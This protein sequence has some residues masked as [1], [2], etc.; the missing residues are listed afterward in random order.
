MNATILNYPGFQTLPKGAKRMLVASEAYFFDQPA[1]YRAKQ[2]G[3][4]DVS[5]ASWFI[6]EPRRWSAKWP[7]E[8]IPM[9]LRFVYG[10][11]W[12]FPYRP[13]LNFPDGF[14]SRGDAENAEM[15][16]GKC[17]ATFCEILT[18]NHVK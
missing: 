16:T 11:A 5:S 10:D 6:P 14:F 4:P 9:Q 13:N 12:P 1:P 18:F 2:N 17:D 15:E 8:T 7:I 3:A